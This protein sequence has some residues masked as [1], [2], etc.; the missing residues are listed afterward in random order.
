MTSRSFVWRNLGK[1]LDVD[2]LSDRGEWFNSHAQAPNVIMVDGIF[3]I[4]FT[5]RSKMESHG[6]YKSFINFADFSRLDRTGLIRVASKPVLELGGL[7]DFDEYGTYPMS[8]L[9]EDG[10]YLAYYGGWTR[11][12]SVPFD[13]S[14]GLATSVD[15]LSFQKFGR[16]PVLTKAISE[17]FVLSS[18][19]IRKFDD[20]YVL[21]YI[22]GKKWTIEDGRPEICY[23]I[24]IAFS[25]DGIHWE[26]VNRDIVESALGEFES[27]A[28][29]DIY[30][31]EN[32]FHMFFCYRNHT[33]FRTNIHSAYK[34][35]YAFSKNLI[36]WNRLDSRVEILESDGEKRKKSCSYPNVF[37]HNGELFMLFLE[38]DLGFGGFSIAKKVHC[39]D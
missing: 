9:R 20:I 31:D 7:G 16:G 18:P 10:R 14:I 36:N 35:G 39:E 24:R 34:I 33:E 6:Q 26:R 5:S 29:P 23:R 13:V 17:P 15:G 2:K 30:Q 38:E 25:T 22:A 8:V 28:S 3:R 11:C 12:L 32:G 1:L 37:N 27:Q 21:S 4:Y 19:K